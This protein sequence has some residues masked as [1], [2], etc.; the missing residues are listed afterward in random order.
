MPRRTVTDGAHTIFTDHRIGIR[1][2][3]DSFGAA[4]KRAGKVSG[5]VPDSLVA[6]HDPAGSLARRNLGLADVNV[7]DRVESFELVNRGFQTLMNCWDDFPNDPAVLT[8]LGR[9]LLAANHAAEA[10]GLFEQAIQ[11]EPNVAVRYL[12]AALAWK[13]AHEDRKAVEN[14]EKTL[15]LDPL[16]EQPYL[17]LGAIYNAQNDA[18]MARRTEERYLRAFPRSLRAQTTAR[19]ISAGLH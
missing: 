5:S 14:L 12:N 10:A 2:P 19:D 1:G 13:A 11:I 6:W 15:R 7:G 4:L 9:G 18:V 17:E 16:L 8:D 3:H